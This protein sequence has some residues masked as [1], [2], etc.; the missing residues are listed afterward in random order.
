MND[1]PGQTTPVLGSSHTKQT[2]WDRPPNKK[3]RR[4]KPAGFRISVPNYA[5]VYA[6]GGSGA[7]FNAACNCSVAAAI[8]AVLLSSSAS[9]SAVAGV[10]AAT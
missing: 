8:A 6:A 5:C 3:P 1:H 2:S 10:P 9:C 4:P 7:G